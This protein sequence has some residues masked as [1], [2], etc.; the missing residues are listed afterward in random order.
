MQKNL[1]LKTGL[2]VA[3]LLIFLYGMLGIP[4][5]LSRAGLKEALLERIH[6]GLDLKGGTHLILVV[7]VNEAVSGE[8]D[9]AA[10]NL[11]Q[12]LTK[13]RIPYADISKPDPNQPEKVV[14]KGVP[15]DSQSQVRSIV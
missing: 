15:L 12:E 6:L 5:S 3:I 9:R 2:I 7:Q 10:E 8:T 14:V 13:A 1:L 4:K 11:K